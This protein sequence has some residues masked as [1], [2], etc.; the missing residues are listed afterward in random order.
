MRTD[1][2]LECQV[3]DLKEGPIHDVQW[4]PNGEHFIVVHGF[5]PAKTTLFNEK[6]KP[7]YDFGSGE[8]GAGG[9][10]RPHPLS[11]PRRPRLTPK[12][13][14]AQRRAV[15]PARA[16]HHAGGLRQ[17]PRGHGVLRQEGGRQV[18]VDGQRAGA[19][20][21][22]LRLGARRPA[23]RDLHRG[24]P[25]ARRQL[26][27]GLQVQ[28][29]AGAPAGLPRAVPGDVAAG[30]GGP[31]PR[32][33]HVAGGLA[34]GQGG[35]GERGGGLR[36]PGG[37]RVRAAP[38]AGQRGRQDQLQPG[39]R[40]LGGR[41]REGQGRHRSGRSRVGE[42]PPRPGTLRQAAQSSARPLDRWL[43]ED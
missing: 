14:P 19:H 4:A 34:G 18:Q 26:L 3:P 38:H 8:L 12:R 22:R 21:G 10:S 9:R 2:S 23:R 32:P 36:G 1:G 37:E 5:M 43:G 6:C 41:P 29:R 7:A 11:S 42:V 27:Q 33:A 17:P 24:S 39:A 28:R 31:V 16:L 35:R 30:P 25:H 40:R 20:D 15:E 13:R